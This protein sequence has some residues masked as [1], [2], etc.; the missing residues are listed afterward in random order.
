M[1]NIIII[2]ILSLTY[3]LASA[4][5]GSFRVTNQSQ[6][7]IGYQ[8]YKYLTFGTSN[9]TPNNGNWAIENSGGVLNFWKP[10]P[11]ANWGN[12]FL[13]ISD[14]TGQVGIGQ[15]PL[16]SSSARLQVNG[17]VLSTGYLTVSDSSTKK[18]IANLDSAYGVKALQRLRPVKYKYIDSFLKFDAATSDENDVKNATI[19]QPHT[20]KLLANDDT[21]IGLIAQEVQKVFPN[22]VTKVGSYEVMDYVG[23]IPILIKG[24]QEQQ[25]T[26][27]QQERKLKQ[28]NDEIVLLKG[29]EFDNNTPKT[30]LF[31]NTPNP[32]KESTVFTYYIDE[33]VPF[34][35][36]EIDIRDIMGMPKKTIK[37]NDKS[38]M[39]KAEFVNTDLTQGYYM[40]SLKIDGQ[41]RDSKMFLV[42]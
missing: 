19:K 33:E 29:N 23:M 13:C 40:Y 41:L 27:E 21:H 38:G 32:F 25:K 24:I 14:A 22:L 4:Q 18:E 39:G 11:S 16:A 12:Y 35:V 34:T 26:I 28:L 2:A 42:E 7:Q 30:R 6:V 10:W 9:S 31:I 3:S 1:K 15:K 17:A 20:D 5:T 37:L 8:G 36:A